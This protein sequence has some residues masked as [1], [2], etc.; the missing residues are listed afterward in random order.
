[1]VV[2]M[3]SSPYSSN[4]ILAKA[5]AMFGN[6]LKVQDY[7]NLLNCHSVSE[8]A[9]YLKNNTSY[10]SVLTE[11]NENTIHRGYLE[12]LLRRKLFNDY[13]AL[14]RYD[15]SVGMHLSSYLIQ[16]SE[17]EEIISC[18]RLMSAGRASE[19]F[20]AIPYFFSS[21]THLDLAKMSQ[22]KTFQ[23]VLETMRGTQYYE[24]LSKF[25]PLENGQI[26]LTKI[27]TALYTQLTNTMFDFISR[28]RG[29]V[30]KELNGLY[31]SY[32]DAQNV[33]RILRLKQFF[34]AS[35]DTIRS[36][37]L[38]YGHCLPD[39]VMNSMISASDTAAV[40]SIFL[41]TPMGRRIPEAQQS[42]LHDLH[43][44]APYYNARKYMHYSI[45]PSVVFL[46]YIIITGV[47]L[48]DIINIIEGVRY[49]LQPD[50]IR[51]M[52]VLANK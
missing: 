29:E 4:V 52:L 3:F 46:S 39:K 16:R 14:G 36:N 13:A 22:C 9:V 51:P 26:Q 1:M 12:Q 30:R 35:P 18:L 5:R 7:N 31:G 34:H 48:D 32:V 23:D 2:D 47:E 49:G 15:L 8:I 28:H 38:P 42:L 43:D 6:S 10:S 40:M 21:H 27:E 50:E 24:I 11:I 19:F 37:L 20:F 17:I 45:Y 25:P 41:S 33:T 44:R